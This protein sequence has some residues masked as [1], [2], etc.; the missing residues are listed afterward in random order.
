MLAF[1]RMTLREKILFHQ[2]HPAKL[3]TDASFA[4]ISLYFFWQHRL[5]VALLLHFIPPVVASAIVIRL[6]DLE[7]YRRSPL[8]AYLVRC[9]TPLAQAARLAGDLVTVFA[10]WFHSPFAIAAGLIVVLAAWT[11]GLLPLQRPHG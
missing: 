7:P 10:A 1:A 5:A 6:A 4:V 9:M 3:A 8:G 2:V 11:Y